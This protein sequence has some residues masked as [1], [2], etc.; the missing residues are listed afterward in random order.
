MLPSTPPA[1]RLWRKCCATNSG[2][3]Q[4]EINVRGLQ[5]RLGAQQCNLIKGRKIDYV[6]EATDSAD[7]IAAGLA[8][9]PAGATEEALSTLAHE[10]ETQYEVIVQNA[11]PVST[12]DSSVASVEAALVPGSR[13]LVHGTPPL[14]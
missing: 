1:T 3:L 5:Q 4:C 11:G 14:L 2:S 13:K 9:G 7:I 6:K 12:P 8:S 10:M